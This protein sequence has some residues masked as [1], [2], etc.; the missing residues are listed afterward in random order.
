MARDTDALRTES[1]WVKQHD[2]SKLFD[3][4]GHSKLKERENVRSSIDSLLAR[5]GT[6]CNLVI[7]AHVFVDYDLD[8][9]CI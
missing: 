2:E 1:R 9:H 6:S 3:H 4:D 5:L 8:T 7:D